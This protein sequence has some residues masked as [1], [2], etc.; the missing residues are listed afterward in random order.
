MP[1]VGGGSGG[2]AHGEI[3]AAPLGGKAQAGGAGAGARPDD[4]VR[5][6]LGTHQTNKLSFHIQGNAY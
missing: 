4:V 5:A 2:G 3:R 6:C 1:L